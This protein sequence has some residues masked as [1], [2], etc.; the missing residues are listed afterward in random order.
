MAKST[1]K[2]DNSSSTTAQ[3]GIYQKLTVVVQELA[4]KTASWATD[5]DKLPGDNQQ[6]SIITDLFMQPDKLKSFLSAETPLQIEP[7]VVRLEDYLAFTDVHL[8]IFDEATRHLSGAESV[9]NKWGEVKAARKNL[10]ELLSNIRENF[11]SNA[12]ATPILGT[13]P[14]PKTSGAN[15]DTCGNKFV[16]FISNATQ[17][18]LTTRLLENNNLALVR[19]DISHL[20]DTWGGV[21]TS[22]I[23]D[24][25]KVPRDPKSKFGRPQTIADFLCTHKELDIL[26][27]RLTTNVTLDD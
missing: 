11:P 1:P 9:R 7:L 17:K 20:V 18:E 16:G 15:L 24:A 23:A 5:W 21:V 12:S 6:K 3:A 25:E 8:E 10:A 2:K 22:F 27:N 13:G 14:A 4:D 19:S 26:Y